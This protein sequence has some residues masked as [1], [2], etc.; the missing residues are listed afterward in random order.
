[1]Q[2]YVLGSNAADRINKGETFRRTMTFTDSAGTAINLASARVSISE[3]SHATL[4]ANAVVTITDAATG[5]VDIYLA[6]EH[7]TLPEGR[8]SWFRLRTVF[9]SLSVDVTDPIWLEIT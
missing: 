3:A 1:M 7:N 6:A 4:T 8:L 5:K 9:G 2:T